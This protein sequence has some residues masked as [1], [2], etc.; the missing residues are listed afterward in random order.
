[1]LKIFA[2]IY[3]YIYPIVVQLACLFISIYLVRYVSRETTGYR[4]ILYI[5]SSFLFYTTAPGL[6][7]QTANPPN[8]KTLEPI[9]SLLYGS[10]A[11]VV[12]K[13]TTDPSSK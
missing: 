7:L 13:L 1:M 9:N 2:Y 6:N 12:M 11:P 8:C 3:I 10:T 5:E 4:L